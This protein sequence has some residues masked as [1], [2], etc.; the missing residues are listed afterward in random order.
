MDTV[1]QPKHYKK[2][3]SSLEIAVRAALTDNGDIDPLNLECFE[4]LVS[5]LTIEEIRGYLRG[6]S[7]KYRWRYRY[8]NNIEDLK[9]AEWYEKKLLRLEEVMT[10][11]FNLEVK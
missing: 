5:M 7:F 6:N 2:D 11:Y 3:V 8:K 1:N 10:N 9:K 4:A